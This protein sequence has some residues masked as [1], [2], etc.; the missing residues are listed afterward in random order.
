MHYSK[1]D[2]LGALI[3]IE[4]SARETLSSGFSDQEKHGY[5]WHNLK[6]GFYFRILPFTTYL[7]TLQL[8]LCHVTAV[9]T[10]MQIIF[11]ATLG[12]MDSLCV[13][14]ENRALL[15]P[16]PV[17]EDAAS[18]AHFITGHKQTRSNRAWCVTCFQRVSLLRGLGGMLRTKN[19]AMFY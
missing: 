10:M 8:V 14:F 2:K 3:W 15:K 19:D 16:V 13:I 7:H 6:A 9:I 5:C 4:T 17:L 1:R 11:S 12:S 18:V